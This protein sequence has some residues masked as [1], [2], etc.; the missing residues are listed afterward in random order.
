[1]IHWNHQITQTHRHTH[2]HTPTHVHTLCDTY[3]YVCFYFLSL[4]RLQ[5]P[6]CWNYLWPDPI[7]ALKQFQTAGFVITTIY[8][9]VKHCYRD[10]PLRLKTNFGTFND[11]LLEQTNPNPWRKKINLQ[12]RLKNLCISFMKSVWHPYLS[13]KYKLNPSWDPNSS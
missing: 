3:Y 4:K 1:M 11:L 8:S 5:C 13:R 10:L 7:T 2:I 12:I 9:N 6:F